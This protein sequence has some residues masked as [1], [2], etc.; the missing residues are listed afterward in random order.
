PKRIAEYVT[1]QISRLFNNLVGQDKTKNQR[2]IL[3]F[4]IDQTDTMTPIKNNQ[5]LTFVK[6]VANAFL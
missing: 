6:S 5:A 1:A 2:Q 4:L 3:V